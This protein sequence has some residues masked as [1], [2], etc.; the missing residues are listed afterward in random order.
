MPEKTEG[1]RRGQQKM[2]LLDVIIHSMDIGLSKLREIVKDRVA[3]HAAFMGS[4]RIGH[5]LVREQ[6]NFGWKYEILSTEVDLNSAS[7]DP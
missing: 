3:W 6:L 5:N 7:K 2:R 4:Q 1:R